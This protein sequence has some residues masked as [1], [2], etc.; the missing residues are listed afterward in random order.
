MKIVIQARW[1]LASTLVLFLSTTALGQTSW[2]ISEDPI[3]K[4]SGAGAEGTFSGLAGTIKFDPQD[5]TNSRFEVSVDPASIATGNKTK[6]KHARGKSWFDVARYT[7]IEFVSSYIKLQ[8]NG[9]VAD[10]VLSM[11]GTSKEIPITFTFT[12]SEVGSATFEGRLTV[13]RQDFEIKGP[14]LSFMVGDEFVI[15][16][17]VPVTK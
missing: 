4:F 9:F 7:R 13:N 12:E 14:L 16:L 1:V 15:D 8:E 10:G 6:D 11:H 17:I 2:K 5:L 3:I